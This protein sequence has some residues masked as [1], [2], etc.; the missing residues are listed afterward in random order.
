MKVAEM[1]ELKAAVMDEKHLG[2]LTVLL[3]H[4]YKAAL[5]KVTGKEYFDDFSPSELYDATLNAEVMEPEPGLY[6]IFVDPSID[7]IA[8][9]CRKEAVN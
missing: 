6:M 1:I 5:I 8:S 9:R 2:D 4:G 3:A 7:P